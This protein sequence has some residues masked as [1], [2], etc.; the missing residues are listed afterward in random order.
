ML[1]RSPLTLIPEARDDARQGW[2]YFESKQVGLGDR[3]IDHILMVL[4]KIAE[5]PLGF[6]EVDPGIRA[7]GVK[8]FGYV[9]Y[10]RTDG[11]HVEVVAILH[12]ARSPDIWKGRV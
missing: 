10:Y 8:R 4:D 1:F 3:F 12:G 2:R 7:F 11:A 6:G 5:M 9:V